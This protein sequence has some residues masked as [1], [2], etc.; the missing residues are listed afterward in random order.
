MIATTSHDN[1]GHSWVQLSGRSIKSM[2]DMR[3]VV[4]LF[5]LLCWALAFFCTSRFDVRSYGRVGSIM[6]IRFPEH[7]HIVSTQS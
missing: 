7:P 2:F 5:R 1:R 3:S 4:G 6:A